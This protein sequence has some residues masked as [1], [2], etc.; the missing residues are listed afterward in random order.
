[1]QRM[2]DRRHR[3]LGRQPAAEILS[4]VEGPSAIL[5]N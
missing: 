4:A 5:E 3:G 2:L 1:M